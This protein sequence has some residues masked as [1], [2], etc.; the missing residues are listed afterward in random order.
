ML[1]IGQ[2]FLSST[3]FWMVGKGN[4][5][6]IL[7]MV[8][9]FTTMC[10]SVRLMFFFWRSYYNHVKTRNSISCL[11]SIS[12]RLSFGSVIFLFLGSHFFPTYALIINI[13]IV[14]YGQ[15]WRVFFF[16][17]WNTGARCGWNTTHC[18]YKKI[19]WRWMS[20]WEYI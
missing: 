16:F 18:Y 6:M 15:Q 7:F 5:V 11:P 10:V 3:L 2:T 9:S 19:N 17:Y 4:A 14:A 8:S 12:H 1:P 20:T 13:I